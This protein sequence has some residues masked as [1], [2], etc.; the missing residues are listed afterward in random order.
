MGLWLESDWVKIALTD[1][2]NQR[3]PA[4]RAAD[5]CGLCSQMPV[6]GWSEPALL[7]EGRPAGEFSPTLVTSCL[8]SLLSPYSISEVSSPGS[9]VSFGRHDSE[10]G[11][12]AAWMLGLEGL[13]IWGSDSFIAF[14]HHCP[15]GYTVTHLAGGGLLCL[16]LPS[17]PLRV[18]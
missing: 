5:A 6:L 17:L 18:D 16:R 11:P 12:L 8:G 3:P 7:W 10:G 15:Q 13:Y 9:A 4:P 14:S 2:T 1:S